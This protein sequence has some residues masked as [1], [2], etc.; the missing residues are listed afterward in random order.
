MDSILQGRV[1]KLVRNILYLGSVRSESSVFE[2]KNNV[3]FTTDGGQ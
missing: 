1:S 2:S 3:D